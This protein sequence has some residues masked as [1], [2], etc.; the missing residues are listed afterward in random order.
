VTV[1]DLGTTLRITTLDT[2]SGQT[3]V[4]EIPK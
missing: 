4:F 2:S 3:T 1:A